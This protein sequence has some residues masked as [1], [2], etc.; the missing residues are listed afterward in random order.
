MEVDLTNDRESLYRTRLDEQVKYLL[1]EPNTFDEET[2]GFPPAFFEHLPPLPSGDWSNARI[3]RHADGLSVE[4]S[5]AELE[6]VDTRHHWHPNMIDI[7]SLTRVDSIS[8]RVPLVK[9][10]C[11]LAVAKF[12]RFEFEISYV[13]QE[14]A[15]YYHIDGK[16]IGPAF[17]GHLTENGRFMGF[18][19]EWIE[20]LTG[21][22]GI[23]G[24]AGFS[25]SDYTR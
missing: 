1:V 25:S 7:L 15:I 24:F 5:Y 8:A 3:C 14:T 9:W 19:I 21:A 23:C 22:L 11:Q 12:A 16:G 10:G 17:L 2:L 13:E 6:R 20:G 18:L 4:L